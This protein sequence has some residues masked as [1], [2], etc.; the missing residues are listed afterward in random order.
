MLKL[1]PMDL[2][3]IFDV[4]IKLYRE[5]F[6]TFLGTAGGVL[7]PAYT[8]LAYFQPTFAN[9]YSITKQI[10]GFYAM[11]LLFLGFF[12]PLSE[13]AIIKAVSERFL[14]KPVSILSAY[15]FI[16]RKFWVVFG[17]ITLSGFIIFLGMFFCFVPGILFGFWFSFLP[18]VIVLENAGFMKAMGRSKKIF[19]ASPGKT[20]LLLLLTTLIVSIAT[21]VS[22]MI[23]MAVV[24]FTL[25]GVVNPMLVAN[26]LNYMV[27]LFFV[28]FTQAS[29]TLLYYDIRI[30]TEGFDLDVLAAGLGYQDSTL[31]CPT[32]G[33]PISRDDTFCGNCGEMLK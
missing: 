31:Q 12:W 18:Q 6:F 32:C 3:A 16:Y 21:S 10:L 2:G 30:R 26:L 28:P 22:G 15:R 20:I 11:L 4:S 8:L 17:T 24:G 9:P 7:A 25:S 1:R 27:A 23:I 5:N 14:D 13:A 19:Q 33:D 29:I